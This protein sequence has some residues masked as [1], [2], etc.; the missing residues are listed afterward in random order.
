MSIVLLP[1][2]GY[3]SVLTER[4]RSRVRLTFQHLRRLRGPFF[5]W[6]A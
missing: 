1:I 5:G 2:A 4:L 6:A 3:T